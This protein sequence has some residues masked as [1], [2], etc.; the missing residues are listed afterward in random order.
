MIRAARESADDGERI[1]QTREQ[2]DG[3]IRRCRGRLDAPTQL[4]AIHPR[5][6]DVAEHEVRALARE[7]GERELRAPGDADVEPLVREQMLEGR[8][9]RRTVL[10][11]EYARR[12]LA[13]VRLTRRRHEVSSTSWA[14]ISVSGSTPCTTPA[15]TASHGMP[16]MTLVAS[17]CAST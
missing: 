15:R 14:A 9:L 4:V 6:D 7:V 3:R 12:A 2:D 10:D 11:D 13:A 5:H 8:G 1:V 16:K 17:S